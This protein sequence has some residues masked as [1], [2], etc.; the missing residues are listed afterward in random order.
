MNPRFAAKGAASGKEESQQVSAGVPED[1]DRA[2]E[3]VQECTEL[4]AELN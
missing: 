4:S 2:A 3:D 1:G